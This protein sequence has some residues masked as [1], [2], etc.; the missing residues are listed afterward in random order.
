MNTKVFYLLQYLLKCGE[1]SHNFGAKAF[2]NTSN[3]RNGKK[4]FYDLPTPR[5]YYS[6]NGMQS[7]RLRCRKRPNI[8]AKLDEYRARAASGAEK[9]R[10]MEAVFTWARD[11][12]QGLDEL[13]PEQRKQ[14]LQMIG[15]EVIVDRDDNVDITLAI[16]IESEPT[17]EDSVTVTSL[18]P[19]CIRCQEHHSIGYFT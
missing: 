11:V 9:L 4:Y 3:I 8:R 7:L 1:C 16:P 19:C 17:T 14:I 6:C 13:I 10:L 12:G 2:W 15:E 18:T 5:L